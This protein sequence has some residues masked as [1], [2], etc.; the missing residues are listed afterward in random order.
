[1]VGPKNLF[2]AKA[3]SLAA[4]MGSHMATAGFMVPEYQRTYDWKRENIERLLEDCLAGFDNCWRTTESASYTFL[5]T[6]ILVNDKNSKEHSFDGTSLAVVDGQQRL[7]TLSIMCCVLVEAL[8]RHQHDGDS[9]KEAARQ[10]LKEE[11][12]F[13][14]GALFDCV[15]G[16]LRERGTN[17]PFPRIVRHTDTRGP[18]PRDAEYRSVVARF[19]QDFARFFKNDT[20]K[21]EPTRQPDVNESMRLFSNYDFIK[22]QL[23]LAL[24]RVGDDGFKLDFDRSDRNEFH[25]RSVKAL[26]EKLTTDANSSNKILADLRNTPSVAPLV[27]LIAFASYITKCVILTRVETEDDSYA[28]DIFDALNTTGEPLTAIETFRP[29]VIQFENQRDGFHGS[30]SQQ[31]LDMLSTH[32]DEVFPKT[33]DR[34]KATKELLVSFAL[35]LNG[36]KLGLPLKAQRSYLRSR[37]DKYSEDAQGE[38]H[39]RRFVKALADVAEFRNRYWAPGDIRTLDAVHTPDASDTI[40]LCFSFIGAMNTSLTLP[41]LARYWVRFRNKEIPESEFLETAKAVTAYIVLRRAV[42]GGTEGIDSE[43]R[44]MMHDRPKTEG[45]PFCAGEDQK[46][47]LPSSSTLKAEIRQRYLKLKSCDATDRTAWVSR[48]RSKPLAYHSRPLCRF[49]I[50]SASHNAMPDN[51]KPGLLTRC[52]VVPSEAL[53]Y[54]S[55]ARWKSELY[56]TVEHVAPDSNTKGLWDS[57]IYGD[58]TKHSLGNL[59]LL[60]H[61]ENTMIGDAEWAKKKLFYRAFA[62][63]TET[64]KRDALQKAKTNGLS[65]SKKTMDLLDGNQQLPMLK[66]LNAVSDWDRTFIEQRSQRLLELAWDQIWPWLDQTGVS[67]GQ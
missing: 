50:L 64:K 37:F 3:E 34:Q 15:I 29:R 31:H 19:L 43:F 11:V 26:F 12:N 16:Q 40:K 7:T 22:E 48:A 27:R 63:E 18:N 10:W 9:L 33:E 47:T 36:R 59:V 57:T 52:G 51:A 49:L 39:R 13:H 17:Y 53:D 55:F 32:L 54:L 21:F 62:A 20:P 66:S 58:D 28:F 24:L 56:A 60:P 38:H 35:Y 44:R 45:D 2:E 30:E 1:M 8:I 42:T 23:D 65:F 25:R 6:I 4:T 5:G 41:L 61:A 46:N 67:K 14:M